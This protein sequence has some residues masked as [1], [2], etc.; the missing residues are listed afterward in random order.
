MEYEHPEREHR[1]KYT[2]VCIRYAT[3]K[4]TCH[5]SDIQYCHLRKNFERIMSGKLERELE[6]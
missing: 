4:E 6:K 3:N 1:C 2:E 5:T